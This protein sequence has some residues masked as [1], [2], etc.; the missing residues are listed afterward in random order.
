[1]TDFPYTT[2]FRS[3]RDRDRGDE[4]VGGSEQV[5]EVVQR[6]RVR[7]GQRA[8]LRELPGGGEGRQHRD[9]ERGERDQRGEGEDQVG[10]R[11]AE[12]TAREIGRASCRGRV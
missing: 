4:A 7:E 3:H 12:Q 6:R 9:Q 11:V 10:A 8:L 2:L 1:M 5:Q